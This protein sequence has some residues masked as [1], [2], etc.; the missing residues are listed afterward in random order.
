MEL[1]TIRVNIKGVRLRVDYTVEKFKDPYDILKRAPIV[2]V[3]IK[4]ISLVNPSDDIKPLLYLGDLYEIE[5]K[6]QAL[7]NKA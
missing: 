6:I 1:Q 3:N 5:D 2:V 7:E 4:Q